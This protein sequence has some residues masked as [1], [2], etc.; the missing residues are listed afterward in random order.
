[1]QNRFLN[2]DHHPQG[3]GASVLLMLSA[4]LSLTGCGSETYEH[5]LNE[6]A[7]YFEYVDI[8]DQALANN[9]SSPSV[10]MRAPIEFKQINGPTAAPAKD[11]DEAETVDPEPTQTIDPR[12]PD[13]IDLVLP[14]LE[15]AWRV[16]VPVE[17][18]N[19]TKD[20]PAYL[21]VLS[22]HYLLKEKM[23]DEALSF[24]DEVNNQL[25]STF[26]QFLNTEE[27]KTEKYPKGK[28]YTD[29]KSFL[30][31]IFEPE[32]EI[33]GV[34]YQL[35]LYLD[36]SGK[37]KIVVLL[38]IPKNISRGSKL[39]E[40]MDYSLETVEIVSPQTG[41]GRK[42]SSSGNAKF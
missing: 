15:G 21:Y 23:M 37:N 17:L 32:T 11:S 38:V 1:M 35:R 36:E 41:G 18:D 5:R 20:L 40:H 9:W 33:N 6:T 27:F 10:K 29:P 31:G 12:Q 42:N 19:E 8:R 7:K 24:H 2:F 16:E 30:V 4:A 28:G 25:A 14:G 13:Y 34:P 22:N 3:I 26:N 39:D